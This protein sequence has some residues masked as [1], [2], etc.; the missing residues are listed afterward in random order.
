MIKKFTNVKNHFKYVSLDT[1][2]KVPSK[3]HSQLLD[4]R[5]ARRYLKKREKQKKERNRK[6]EEPRL[7]R[8]SEIKRGQEREKEA[9]DGILDHPLTL[10][11]PRLS[12]RSSI[13]LQTNKARF[14]R[15]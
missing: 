5:G 6:K 3:V 11:V 2:L 13:A 9:F 10:F 8:D 15:C 1:F 4:R 7:N 14:Y 12:E